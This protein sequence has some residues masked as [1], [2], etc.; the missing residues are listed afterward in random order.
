MKKIL[1]TIFAA[2]ALML[3]S[4]DMNLEQPGSINVGESVQTVE[5]VRG[6]RNNLYSSLRALCSGAYITDVE[7]QSD[8]FIGLRGNG[9]RGSTM[10]QGTFTPSTGDISDNYSGCYSVMKT[11]NFTL[12]Q[13]TA[14][15]ESG[16]VAADEI[17]ELDRYI[18]ET[19]FMR[20][21][22]YYWLFD[23]YCQSYAPDKA[24]TPGLGLQLVTVYNPN[25][26][27]AEYPGRSTMKAAIDLINA[28]LAAAYEGLLEWEAVDATECA[29]NA[30]YVSSYAVAAL[31]AR[32]A[33]LTQ[34]YT[35]AIAKAQHVTEAP[36]YALATGNDYI[37]MWSSDA[38]TELLFVPF[39]DANESSYVGS[40]FDAYNYVDN[41]PTRVD[42]V[43]SGDVISSYS[44]ADI[45]FDAF[46]AGLEMTVDAQPT[47]A[48]IFYKFPGN[49]ALITGSN[50]NYKNKPKPFRLSEL[51]L[52]I[53]EAAQASNQ[54]ALANEALK[55]LREARISGYRHQDYSGSILR[56]EIRR[57]RAKELIGEGFRISDLRRWGLGFSRND[58]YE[59]LG[60]GYT[61]IQ[62]LF[63]SGD[64][65]VRYQPNDYRYTWP[66]PNDEFEVNAQLKGQQ[67][68]GYN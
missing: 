23:H 19:R 31:Q 34:D 2:G 51:Y 48:F 9:G 20:A 60:G 25:M 53:A 3:S 18:A 65:A 29:P 39:V 58:H 67:N 33:L 59:D 28:D 32:V 14:L 54:D 55:T 42:Y 27:P 26:T 5:D 56:D 30:S 68:P 10:S 12:E 22:I 61:P 24:E 40:F 21:Y 46:F 66:I 15:K 17:P 47:A 6:F 16:T 63:L 37:N 49:Q 43:P 11:V 1:T 41:F 52:I 57:E 4:C 35:T 62:D 36:N 8:F 7:L 64:L 13:A 38:G 44:D 50:N 45:R